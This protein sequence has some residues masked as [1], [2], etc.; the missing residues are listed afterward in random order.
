MIHQKLWITRSV[1][2]SPLE[3]KIK[4]DLIRDR[5][6]RLINVKHTLPRE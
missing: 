1:D 2:I 6:I 4:A 5:S 3:K